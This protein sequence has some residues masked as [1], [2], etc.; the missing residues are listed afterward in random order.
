MMD[1]ASHLVC[2]VIYDT[3]QWSIELRHKGQLRLGIWLLAL[4]CP[5]ACCGVVYWP[6]RTLAP[7]CAVDSASNA[8]LLFDREVELKGEVALRSAGVDDTFEFVGGA[9]PV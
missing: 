1:V 3:T 6:L 9:P 5:A 8:S 4:Q 7:Y 2:D